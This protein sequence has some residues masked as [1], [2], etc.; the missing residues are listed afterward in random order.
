[1]Q[2]PSGR[3]LSRSD[4]SFIEDMARHGA[5]R[6]SE[7]E[8]RLDCGIYTHVFVPGQED[9]TDNV[10]FEWRLGRKIAHAVW[11]GSLP[12]DRQPCLIGIPMAGAVLAQAGAMA[13]ARVQTVG[14]PDGRSPIGSSARYPEIICAIAPGLLEILKSTATPTGWWTM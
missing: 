3:E 8:L 14:K 13:S 2:A 6:Y 12:E 9:L 7:K 4:I 5:V 10:Q 11:D 1:M